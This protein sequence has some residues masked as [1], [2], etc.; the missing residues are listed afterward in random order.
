M[1]PPLAITVQQQYQP[2]QID[3]QKRTYPRHDLGLM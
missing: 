1:S 2:H 3:Q